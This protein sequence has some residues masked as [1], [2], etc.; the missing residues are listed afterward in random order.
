MGNTS[1][2]ACRAGA[3]LSRESFRGFLIV[4][5][6]IYILLFYLVSMKFRQNHGII[7]LNSVPFLKMDKISLPWRQGPRT[8]RGLCSS[9][10]REEG[11]ATL[12]SAS[13]GTPTTNIGVVIATLRLT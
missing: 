2:A 6:K 4:K 12:A 3:G 10:R 7:S 8:I 1:E 13:T 11:K 9:H 5:N